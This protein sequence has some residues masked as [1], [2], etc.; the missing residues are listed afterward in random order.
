VRKRKKKKKKTL[1][2][3]PPQAVQEEGQL[4]F[5]QSPENQAPIPGLDTKTTNPE[6]LPSRLNFLLLMY[7]IFF[8]YY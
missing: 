3:S 6:F 4:P 7:L 5:P 8:L 1:Q 2:P